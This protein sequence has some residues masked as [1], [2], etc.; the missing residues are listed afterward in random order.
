MNWIM[1]ISIFIV[2]LIVFFA[3]MFFM[4]KPKVFFDAD[5]K[6]LQ[7]I[8]QWHDQVVAEVA[9]NNKMD[10]A[11][12][13]IY[14]KG[15]IHDTRF[16]MLYTALSLIPNIQYMGLINIKEDF[17][18][19]KKYGYNKITDSTLRYFYTLTASGTRKSGIWIDG[20]RKFFNEKEWIV[21]DMSREN[22]LFNK[23]KYSSTTVV[24]LDIIRPE[25]IG[26]GAS[27]NTDINKDDIAK[28]FEII[29]NVYA[30]PP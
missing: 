4:P 22:S 20:E 15:N 1:T 21:A 8:I 16:P 17:S 5:I 24:F 3:F 18:Q 14:S 13:P 29:T 12:I 7:Y 9:K 26:N 6:E 28:M 11:V 30:T 2:L 19:K 27:P 10:S 23:D 25:W